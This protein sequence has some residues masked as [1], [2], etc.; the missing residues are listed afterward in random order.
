MSPPAAPPP[1]PPRYRRFGWPLRLFLAFLLFDIVFRSLSVLFPWADWAEELK[2]RTMP[3]R[4]ATRAELARKVA[5]AR[6]GESPVLEDVMVACD[7][8]WEYFKPWPG[9]ETRP[10]LGSWQS[11]GR[12]VL[13][14]L[15]SRLEFCENVVGINEEW[16]MFSPSTSRKKYLTRA[17]LFYA[18]GSERILRNHAD[19]EDLTRYSH[20]NQEKVLDHELHVSDGKNRQSD[21]FGYCNLLSHRHARNENGAEL[22]RI[23]LFSIRYDLTPP[24]VADVREYL[25][26]RTGPPLDQAAVAGVAALAWGGPH[27]TVIDCCFALRVAQSPILPWGQYYPDFYDYDVASREGRYLL[28]K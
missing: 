5:E 9:P 19:P 18:D 26:A 10:L 14:W 22:I 13:C 23:R 28:E 4:L 15:S 27:D 17:R 2:M 11:R 21:A 6:P 7:S 16:P 12:F 20:W 1:G 3:E 24:D 8:I 25:R